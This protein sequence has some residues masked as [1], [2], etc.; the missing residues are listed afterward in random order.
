MGS[1]KPPG[2]T[3]GVGGLDVPNFEV[4]KVPQ[5]GDRRK[6]RNEIKSIDQVGKVGSPGGANCAGDAGGGR[7]AQWAVGYCLCLGE[8][9]GGL[10]FNS[11]EAPRAGTAGNE[12]A[13]PCCEVQE[14]LVRRALGF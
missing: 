10:A 11:R 14:A 12:G 3:D 9:G 5:E 13:A 6:A 2:L 4:V 7:K 8:E 1:A